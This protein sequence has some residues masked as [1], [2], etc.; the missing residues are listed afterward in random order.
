MKRR[1]FA[2]IST[3][4]KE[5]LSADEIIA[6]ARETP[7]TLIAMCTHG[8]SGFKQWALGCVTDKVLHYSS[9]PVLMVPAKT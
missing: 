7:D 6:V 5:G 3:L 9:N 8:R 1:G 4:A 2:K